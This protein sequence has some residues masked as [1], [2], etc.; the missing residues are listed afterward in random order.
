MQYIQ[1]WA[2]LIELD[3]ESCTMNPN[4]NR[5]LDLTLNPT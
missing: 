5:T 1:Y 4:H 3:P 2:L